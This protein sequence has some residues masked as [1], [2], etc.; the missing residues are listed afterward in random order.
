MIRADVAVVSAFLPADLRGG[1]ELTAWEEARL[2]GEDRRVVLVTTSSPTADGPEQVQVGAWVRPLYHPGRP[3]RSLSR[4]LA[5]HGLMLFNPATFVEALVLFRRLRPRVVHTHNLLT[6]SPSIWLAARLAG[7]RVVHTHH[8]LWPLCQRSTMTR[9]DGRYCEERTALCLLCR[10]TR[11]VKRAE[12]AL[13]DHEI[14]PSRWLRG[15]LRR[16]GTVVRPFARGEPAAGSGEPPAVVFLGRLVEAKG[17]RVLLEAFTR[18]GRD[19]PN[20][21]LVVAGWGPLAPAV[22][23]TPGATHLGEVDEEARRNLL[24]R[25]VAVVVPSIGPDSSSAVALE[26]LATGVPVIVSDAGGLAELGELGAIVVA[27]GDARALAEALSGVLA[28]TYA[29]PDRTHEIAS[30]ERFRRE[31]EGVLRAL[32]RGAPAAR[33][34]ASAG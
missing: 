12:L 6:L 31:L 27:A 14:F 18:L 2:L 15:R 1:A 25:A 30:P 20:T 9:Q 13:V 29:A 28:G 17:V 22:R 32:E 24:A 11:P 4:R 34:A 33:G 21:E 23:R 16:D 3:D 26:A 5:S 19:H 10:A 7:A 8:D